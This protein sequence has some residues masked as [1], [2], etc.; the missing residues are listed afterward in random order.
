VALSIFSGAWI[1]ILISDRSDLVHEISEYFTRSRVG[2]T[3]L[4]TA[5]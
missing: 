4:Q 2:F 1:L 3:W 5:A